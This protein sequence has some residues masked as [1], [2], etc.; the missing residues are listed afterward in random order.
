MSSTTRH[1]DDPEVTEPQPVQP[2]SELGEAEELGPADE[3]AP[4]EP[5]GF[6]DHEWRTILPLSFTGFF[7]N[8]DNV[9]LT[10]GAPLIYTGLRVSEGTFGIAVAIIKIA[11]IGSLPVLRLADRIGRKRMLIISLVAFTIA[12]GATSLAGS[13]LVFVGCQIVARVFL[14]TEGALASLVVAEEVRPDR[15]GRAL[16]LMGLMAQAGGGLVAIVVGIFRDNPL[17]WRL[18]YVIALAPLA[19]VAVLRRSLRETRAFTVAANSDRIQSSFWPR[20]EASYR[21]H[22]WTAALLFGTIG[23]MQT[24]GFYYAAGIAQNDFRWEGSYTALI[25]SSGIF[26]TTGF[27]LGGR[28]SDRFGRRPILAIGA[29]VQS[30]GVVLVFTGQ[31]VPYVAGFY[32]MVFGQACITALYLAY[33]SELVPTEVRATVVS[34]IV[35]CNI[36]GGSI[37]LL[38]AA[39]LAPRFMTT[40][41]AL[42][43]FAA[44]SMCS[45]ITLRWLPET[46]GRDVIEAT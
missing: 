44:L 25:L 43:F 33:V 5:L 3:P 45:L 46:A 27:L 7:E 9:I 36:G 29:V 32:L 4:R 6:N 18:F 8:Y 12:T 17:G 20:L 24:P 31:Q 19:V 38:A 23:F 42:W 26:T 14:T 37:G 30:L 39:V 1:F 40:G 22:V 41:H 21:G 2:Q 34:F 15:R 10:L 35:S 28:G 13:L 11:T 16:S